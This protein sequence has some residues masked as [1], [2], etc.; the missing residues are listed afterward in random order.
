M[1]D[2]HV[3]VLSSGSCGN[4]TLVSSG[5]T[6]L[7]IDAGISCRELERRLALFGADPSDIDAVLLTH[8]HT[9]HNRGA[10]R[11]CRVHDVTLYGTKSTLALTPH[12]G[13]SSIAISCKTVFGIGDITVQPFP[14]KH[15]A[16]DP[17]AFSMMFKGAKVSVASDLGSVTE[18]VRKEMKD[19]NLL[20][21]E[22]N[23]DEDML[24]NGTYPGFLKRAILSARG[25]LSNEEAGNLCAGAVCES[26]RDIVLLHLSRENN[27]THIA[28]EAVTERIENAAP[29][30]RITPTEH[31]SHSGPF[32][33]G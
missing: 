18:R 22:A 1:H 5:E 10:L 14:V 20:M 25:H 7:L 23:Y 24:V 31:G 19:S 8:E 21:I 9:D 2:S 3:A 33:L 26:L 4:S 15:L 17:V 29:R 16:A 11:F 32:R 30:V 28:R 13:V 27:R 12:D 6:T